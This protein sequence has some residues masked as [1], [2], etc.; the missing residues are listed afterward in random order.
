[1]KNLLKIILNGYLSFKSKDILIKITNNV[2]IN[3]SHS[4]YIFII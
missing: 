3:L 1:M 4:H 2:N